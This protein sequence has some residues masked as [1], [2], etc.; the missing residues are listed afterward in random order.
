[1]KRNLYTL[2]AI[3]LWAMANPVLASNPD[4][5]KGA[6]AI[7]NQEEKVFTV[8]SLSKGTTYIKRVVTIFNEGGKDHAKLYVHHDKLNK[9]DFIKGTSYDRNG[10]KI[11]SLKNSEIRNVSASSADNEVLDNRIM[12]AELTHQVYPYKVEFE[13]QTTTSNMLFYPNWVPLNNSKTSIAKATFQVKMPKGMKLRYRES[14]LSQGVKQEN[15]ATH[16]VYNWEITNMTPMDSEP[17]APSMI[18]LLPMVRTAPSDFEVQGYKGNMDTWEAYGKWINQLNE[19][20]DALPE[21]TKAKLQAMVAGIDDPIEKINKVYHYLQ[22]N[23]RYVSIQLGLGGW[24]PFEAS[25][26]DSKGY[27]DCKALTNY[28]KAMLQAVG[29][30]SIYAL[31]NGG[32]NEREV[33]T[34]FPSSQFNHVI[35]CV[36]TK[37]DTVWLECTS[38]FESAGYSGSFTGDRHALLITKDGGKLVKTQAYTAKDNLQSRMATVKL[39]ETGNGV[40][41]VQTRYTGI[42]HEDHLDP[43]HHLSPEEQRKWLY[44]SIGI[45]AFDLKSFSFDLKK[46]RMP[47]VNE[48]LELSLRQCVTVSGKRMFLTP[49]LMNRWTTLPQ[50]TGTRKYDVVRSSAYTNVDTIVYEMPAGFALEFKPNDQAFDTEFGRFES[51][52]NIDG[53]QV[54]YIRTLQMHK[55]RF[56]PEVYATMVAFMNDVYKADQ[57][58]VVFVKNIQ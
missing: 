41:Q 47:E 11:K 50:N 29:I 32:S 37:Q 55:G 27:G 12:I 48:K 33:L 16:D 34:D 18:E 4:L 49:N 35:L 42:A 1:M 21:A 17:Y 58:Q 30:P 9:V 22:S 38:Q 36:P 57:Q 2:L 3:V 14:N 26:V 31:V 56:K 54:T 23:T 15:T 10:K 6:N 44:R 45:P 40:A 8:H 28:T 19:G 13:Y 52:V 39:D 46:G 43:I 7:I 53:R 51:K 5:L 20:R 24:Q 25:F